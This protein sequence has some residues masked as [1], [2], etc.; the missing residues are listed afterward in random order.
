MKQMEGRKSR[1]ATMAGLFQEVKVAPMLEISTTLKRV[2]MNFT[3]YNC[4]C[5]T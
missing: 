3:D 1:E 5:L 4:F 2:K